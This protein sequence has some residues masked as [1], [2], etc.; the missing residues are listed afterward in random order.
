MHA[1]LAAVCHMRGLVQP[2]P[3]EAAAVNTVRLLRAGR[4]IMRISQYIIVLTGF[5]MGVL[6][7]PSMLAH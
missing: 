7:T 3:T 1:C 4:Q 5:F 6:V 2:E